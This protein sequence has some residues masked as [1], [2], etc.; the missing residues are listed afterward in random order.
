[1]GKTSGI[2][3]L[4]LLAIFIIT[5]APSVSY[6]YDSVRM[7][8]PAV[9]NTE[10]G[11]RGAMASLEVYA[12]NGSGHVFVDTLPLTEL[13]TQAGARIAKEAVEEIMEKSLDDYDIFFVIRSDAP[14]VGGPSAGSS[15]A[16]AL[17]A[18]MLNASADESVIM[19]GTINLDGSIG[20]VGGLIE[21]AQAVAEHGG[22]LF[23]V[24]E[25]QLMFLMQKTEHA[26]SENINIIE[27]TEEQVNLADYAKNKWN[28][29]VME[30]S[31]IKQSLEIISGYRI[32]DSVFELNKNSNLESAMKSMAKNFLEE[33]ESRFSEAKT[34]LSKASIGYQEEGQMNLLLGEQ[35]NRISDARTMFEQGEYY[36]SSSFCY[37][38]SANMRFII[39]YIDTLESKAP[40]L[41]LETRLKMAD[42]RLEPLNISI[43]EKKSQTDNVNDIEII[44][45]SSERLDEAREYM[46]ASWKS[47]YNEQNID[48][49]YS[50][51]YAEEREATVSR[52]LNL[53]NAFSGQGF[54]F[55]FSKL[56]GLAQLRLGEAMSFITYAKLLGI[57][58]N[59]SEI[60]MEN[61]MKNFE[62]ENYPASLFNTISLQAELEALMLSPNIR[63]ESSEKSFL[64]SLETSALRDIEAA[65]KSGI[66]PIMAMNYYEYGKTLEGKSPEMAV[67]YLTYAKH[68]AKASKNI[69]EVFEG[70][71]FGD[72]EMKIKLVKSPEVCESNAKILIAVA[73]SLSAGLVIGY[74]AKS[75]KAI[76]NI[77]KSAGR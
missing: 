29:T 28:L 11:Q 25:G 18:L 74:F 16:T 73:L 2:K 33:T 72:Y 53:T 20:P 57:P 15:M 59:E 77:R 50:L 37:V 67:L 42:S 65:Q 52:W 44:L 60:L 47:F 69:M 6:C 48:S 51:S 9:E 12:R 71:S 61:A 32:I 34:R 54:N 64:I 23:L 58:T 45:L 8:I 7:Y 43:E 10:N 36:S 63:Y 1:M 66:I 14:I 55:S 31:D 46:K 4:L 49:A 35:E 41:F 21:K 26:T 40:S 27:A 22:R 56:K 68:F 19:T 62:E 75:R 3:P 39:N 5:A 76:K 17:L 30:V 13:D 70:S 38:A 24:P